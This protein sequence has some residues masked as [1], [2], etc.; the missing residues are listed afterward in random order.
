MSKLKFPLQAKKIFKA[1]KDM[2]IVMEPGYPDRCVIGVVCLANGIKDTYT[3][4]EK[5]AE[6]LGVPVKDLAALE[7]GFEGWN[8]KH[9]ALHLR[10]DSFSVRNNEMPSIMK[11]RYY[12]VGQNLRKMVDNAS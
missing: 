8:E 6:L 11:N 5:H 1:A 12:K 9:N 4:R 7:C 3:Y 2:D 10:W